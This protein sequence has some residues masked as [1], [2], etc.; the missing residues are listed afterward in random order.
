VADDGVQR[1]RDDHGKIRVFVD[2]LEQQR[3]PVG[4]EEQAVLL[5][6]RAVDRHPDVVEQTR[7]GDHHLGVPVAHPVLRHHRR[8]HAAPAQKPEQPQ[9]DVHDD[10]DV[11][12][13]VVRHVAP[14]G[15]DLLH[16]PP[17]VQAAVAVRRREQG[18]E[19]AV[20]A[21]RRADLRQRHVHAGYPSIR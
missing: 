17:R 13:R 4:R 8:L 9:G 10:L 11:D 18:L 14:V 19:L 7:R 20:A 3:H 15:V 21:R 6:V 16:V 5:V 2:P 1:L 12:P